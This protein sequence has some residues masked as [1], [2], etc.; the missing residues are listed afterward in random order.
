MG[1]KVP[2]YEDLKQQLKARIETGEWASGHRLP[3]EYELVKQLGIGRHRARQA[4]RELEVE[5]YIVRKQ[6]SGSY[7][8][9]ASDRTPAIKVAGKEAVAMFF[10][11]Y[12]CRYSRQVVDGFMRHMA[13]AD[14]RIIMYN[15]SGEAPAERES[16]RAT[17]DSG[18]AGL[19]AWIDHDTLATR[20][21]LSALG[22]RRFPVVL[23]DRYLEGVDIDYVVSANEDIGYRLTRALI[24]NGHRRIAFVG[25]KE[26]VSSIVDR[27]KGYQRALREAGLLEDDTPAGRCADHRLVLDLELALDEPD[28][29]VNEVMS[30]R[31]RPTAFVCVN[32]LFAKK[33]YPELAK[34]GYT[35]PDDIE[36]AAVDDEHPSENTE[37]PMARI[38]Q[39]AYEVGAQSAEVL[40]ARVLNPDLAVQRRS[41][42]AG[43][44]VRDA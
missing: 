16:L 29:V 4:L 11:R 14:R 39:N 5:G 7:V 44:V 3:S 24:E 25:Y 18:V 8:L 9:P 41:I 19:V 26:N 17:V 15:V 36:F 38:A 40:L 33:V 12:I 6:G 22:K 34:R 31:D 42:Q 28:R 35:V 10:P 20:R 21:L 2:V 30:L 13:D 43:P 27:F 1:R 37:I 32:D 23:A